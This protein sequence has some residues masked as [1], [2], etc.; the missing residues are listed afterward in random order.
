MAGWR[1]SWASAML[2]NSFRE[3]YLAITLGEV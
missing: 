1:F 2:N 3:D